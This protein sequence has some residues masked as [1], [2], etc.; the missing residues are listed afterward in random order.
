MNGRD[1]HTAIRHIEE[2]KF[3]AR[4]GNETRDLELAVERLNTAILIVDG[5]ME[6]DI[7]EIKD[8]IGGEIY[9][10]IDELREKLPKNKHHLLTKA[11]D[12]IKRLYGE[13]KTPRSAYKIPQA[14]P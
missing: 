9:T 4:Q 5:H 12:F 2:A 10:T 1:Y 8:S 14:V 11:N 7:E 13:N 3:D 6:N